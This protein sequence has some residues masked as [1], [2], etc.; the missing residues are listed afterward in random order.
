VTFREPLARPTIRRKMEPS[1]TLAPGACARQSFP[2]IPWVPKVP[3]ERQIN[4]CAP[5]GTGRI[6]CMH[7]CPLTTTMPTGRLTGAELALSMS[8]FL[9]HYPVT[10]FFT[11]TWGDWRQ[12][13]GSMGMDFRTQQFGEWLN[14]LEILKGG[15]V[16]WFYG[17]EEQQSG[18]GR[19]GIATH[20]HGC[21]VGHLDLN[22]KL[23]DW[24]WRSIAGDADIR[25]YVPGG[26]AIRYCF[27]KAFYRIGDWDFGNLC[28]YAPAQVTGASAA[29]CRR[30]A[31]GAYL[32]PGMTPPM[33]TSC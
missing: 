15:P 32:M 21:L 13:P 26:N 27:K 10:Q 20:L 16:G 18:V 25:R 4:T 11:L 29:R 14:A 7:T 6:T 8:R 33:L 17:V 9:K 2:G 5:K 1:G 28:Y 19:P 12:Q 24:L 3:M 30:L 23:G 22:L 31:K